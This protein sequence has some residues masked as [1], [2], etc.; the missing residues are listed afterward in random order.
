[1]NGIDPGGRREVHDLVRTLAAEG[2]TI[3]I[4]SHLLAELELLA[5]RLAVIARGRLIAAGT[6]AELRRLIDD[7]P[8]TIRLESQHARRWAALLIE[9]PEVAQVEVRHDAVTVRT[10]SPPEFFA[11]LNELAARREL[12]V[13]RLETLDAG[14]EA[15]FGYLQRGTS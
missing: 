8:L 13:E 7:E 14:A 10:T 11:A 15:V 9:R 5:D 1:L 12:D 4:S 6:L 3:V 2:L